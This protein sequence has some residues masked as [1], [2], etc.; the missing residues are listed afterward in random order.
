[1]RKYGLFFIMSIFIIIL[2]GCNKLVTEDDLI[3]G[4]WVPKSG[5]IDG[6]PSGDSL[7][8]PYDKGVEFKNEE[9]VYVEGKGIKFKGEETLYVEKNED[10]YFR[11]HL[12]ESDDG[13]KIEFYNPNGETD[14]FK[15]MIEN[16]DNLV[17]LGAG[18]SENH[19]CYFERKK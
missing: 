7:C 9:T 5:Y 10:K 15:I 14:F 8:P 1:M 4:K 17:L 18:I 13:M 12:R 16:E 11:Y 6:E 2:G 3:G 19:N